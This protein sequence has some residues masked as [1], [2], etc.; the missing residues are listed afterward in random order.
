MIR[1]APAV[2]ADNLL[3]ELSSPVLT[4][5]EGLSIGVSTSV[6]NLQGTSLSALILGLLVAWLGIRGIDYRSRSGGA[7]KSRLPA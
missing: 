4:P 3:P 1:S 2:I 7:P 5:L 6:E